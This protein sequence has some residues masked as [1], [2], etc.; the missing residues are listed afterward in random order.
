MSVCVVGTGS[1]GRWRRST[2][3]VWT[4]AA[5]GSAQLVWITPPPVF[6]RSPADGG[7]RSAIISLPQPETA[8]RRKGAAPPTL[9]V[10]TAFPPA[11][12]E[13]GRLAV[14]PS[15]FP[16]DP[17]DAQGTLMA[18]KARSLDSSIGLVVTGAREGCRREPAATIG[19]RGRKCR[20]SIRL[21]RA[22]C[23]R[24]WV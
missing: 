6:E 22:G 3:P 10:T 17:G 20:R 24:L 14:P 18:E 15:S 11:Q 5:S 1:S 21:A 7:S 8:P 4:S 13:P 2:F 9:H 16:A 12:Q 23:C 19:N